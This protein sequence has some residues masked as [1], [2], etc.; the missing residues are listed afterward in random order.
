M[1]VC[2][3]VRA[4]ERVCVDDECAFCASVNCL[5]ENDAVLAQGSFHNGSECK[6]RC[7]LPQPCLT[8][9]TQPRRVFLSLAVCFKQ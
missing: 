7:I 4:C 9:A 6:P 5:C 3:C 2:A 8:I 1:C